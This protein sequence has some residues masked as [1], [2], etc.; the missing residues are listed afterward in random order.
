LQQKLMVSSPA[1]RFPGQA[2][3]GVHV[4][5]YEPQVALR[6]LPGSPGQ[7]VQCQL[8]LRPLAS[9]CGDQ[10]EARSLSLGRPGPAEAWPPLP[11][12]YLCLAKVRAAAWRRLRL[13]TGTVTL[14]LWLCH[15]Q[16]R[17]P[18]STARASRSSPTEKLG[19]NADILFVFSGRRSQYPVFRD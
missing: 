18:Y 8:A 10:P 5:W 13:V 9:A 3:T 4:L 15:W 6:P 1:A 17:W 19:D 7:V 11:S 12:P 2:H 16:S 14:L